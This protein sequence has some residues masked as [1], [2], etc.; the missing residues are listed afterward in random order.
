MMPAAAQLPAASAVRVLI[1]DDQKVVCEAVRQ[2]LQ[3]YPQ[4]AFC[5]VTQPEQFL[6]QALQF[7]P[8]VVLLDLDLDGQYGLDLARQMRACPQ[9]QDV[10]VVVL[11]AT[12][13]AE[14]KQLAFEQ[15]V[16]DYVVKLP[17]PPE[18]LARIRYHSSNYVNLLER[19]AAQNAL[20]FELEEG[21]RYVS[22]LFPAPMQERGLRVRWR[23]D[24]CTRLAGD[25]FGYNWDDAEHFLFSLH[26]VCGHGVASALHSVSVLNFI[27]ARSLVGGDFNDPSG[28]LR[29]LNEAF[30]MD[31]HNGLFLTLWY[32]V[33]EPG[34]RTLRYAC[35]GH[36]PALLFDPAR[37]HE[38]QRLSAGGPA[39]G[40]DARSTY[41]TGTVTV[42]PGGRIYLF[43]DGVY[44][45]QRADGAG[46][47]G[48]EAFERYLTDAVAAGTATVD[49]IANWVRSQQQATQFEDDFTLLEILFDDTVT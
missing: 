31:R 47:L 40:V 26:D 46:L 48:Y 41:R 35:G 42:P 36:P 33:Y 16:N 28:V 13:K 4:I 5:A 1:V 22:S 10:P 32:G 37:P 24:A 25:A 21:C 20:N 3:P 30:D 49:S 44:E 29:R 23:F 11:S 45:V 18:L 39:V 38:A 17:E 27:R 8:T 6:A 34:S 12:E 9:L 15:G 19:N 14:T 2:V 43:S 7:L